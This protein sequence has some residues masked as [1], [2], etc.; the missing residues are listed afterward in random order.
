MGQSWG[1][2]SHYGVRIWLWGRDRGLAMGLGVGSRYGAGGPA[3]G[4]GWG[5]GSRYGAEVGSHYGAVGS[6]PHTCGALTFPPPS[7]CSTFLP[8]QR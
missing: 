7:Q 6:L 3:M 8:S 2:G 5:W 1:W 4:Q